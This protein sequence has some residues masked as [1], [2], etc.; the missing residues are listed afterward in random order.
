MWVSPL[1][2][3]SGQ[4]RVDFIQQIK[5]TGKVCLGGGVALLE[6]A[7]SSSAA[8]GVPEKKDAVA[9]AKQDGRSKL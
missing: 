8:Q 6:P 5:A 7:G 2:D 1:A 3:G 9:L 4:T